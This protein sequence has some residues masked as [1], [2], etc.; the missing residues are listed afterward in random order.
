MSLEDLQEEDRIESDMMD[1][2]RRV[3]EDTFILHGPLSGI[4]H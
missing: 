4:Y 3:M 2:A 1:L